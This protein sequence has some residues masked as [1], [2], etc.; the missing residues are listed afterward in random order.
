MKDRRL[1]LED[2]LKQKGNEYQGVITPLSGDASFRRYFRLE[3]ANINYVVMDAP[4]EKENAHY[5][6]QLARLFEGQGI[7]VPHV[8]AEDVPLGFL[9]LSDFGDRQLLGELNEQTADT[10]YLQ[11]IKTLIQWQE[12]VIPADISMPTFDNRLYQYELS[13]FVDWFLPKY[14]GVNI[15]SVEKKQFTD[16]YQQL[17]NVA[18][19]QPQVLV[20]R[21]YHSRNLMLCDDGEL[22]VLDFQDAVWGPITYDLVS[23]LRDCYVATQKLGKS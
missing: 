3:T 21:D 7:R 2:W 4:P 20:H 13:L 18:M 11:A 14:C 23:L 8:Y 6:A 5:F 17:I 1:L 15:S 22:G 9:I 10:L 16:C 19:A 12:M